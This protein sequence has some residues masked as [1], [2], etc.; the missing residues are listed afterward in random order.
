MVSYVLVAAVLLVSLV[1]SCDCSS[2]SVIKLFVASSQQLQPS[3]GKVWASAAEL[4]S[5]YSIGRA[6]SAAAFALLNDVD[7]GILQKLMDMVQ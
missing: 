4:A 6:E 5:A 2:S 3:I 1:V 7:G